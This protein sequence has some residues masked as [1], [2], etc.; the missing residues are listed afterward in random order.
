MP[1][2]GLLRP[3]TPACRPGRWEALFS[4]GCRTPKL[5]R[6]VTRSAGSGPRPSGAG[7]RNTH[8]VVKWSACFNARAHAA[9]TLLKVAARASFRGAGG[10]GGS[11]LTGNQPNTAEPQRTSFPCDADKQK[12]KRQKKR[13]P[14]PGLVCA[15]TWVSPGVCEDQGVSER[16]WGGGGLVTA[17]CP[18]QSGS[19]PCTLSYQDRFWPP[20]TPN[21]SQ[22]VGK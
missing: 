7:T 15:A 3:A 22:W 16:V 8:Q 19:P 17:W 5:E 2:L 20:V 18:V 11:G 12:N 10:Q 4:C 13:D 14:R 6:T 1:H 21:C 9:Q